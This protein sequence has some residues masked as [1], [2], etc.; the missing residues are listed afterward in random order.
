[1][2]KL[3]GHC[4]SEFCAPLSACAPSIQRNVGNRKRCLPEVLKDIK[5][6]VFS[7]FKNVLLVRNTT[8]DADPL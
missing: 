8:D 1:M 5:N 3:S 4:G 6:S 7:L 2:Y